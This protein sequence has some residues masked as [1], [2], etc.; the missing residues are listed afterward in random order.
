MG[1]IRMLQACSSKTNM[2]SCNS[3]FLSQFIPHELWD[4]FSQW[5]MYEWM[6]AIRESLRNPL[7][8][9]INSLTLLWLNQ[10]CYLYG[11]QWPICSGFERVC[12]LLIL[13]FPSSSSSSPPNVCVLGRENLLSF[14]QAATLS[15][16]VTND[17]LPCPPPLFPFHFLSA[18]VED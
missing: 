11:R 15:D 9:C 14:S 5:F 2:T 13:L 3:S 1:S 7:T 8:K 18:L 6:F 17:R 16:S 12:V 10:R 4:T